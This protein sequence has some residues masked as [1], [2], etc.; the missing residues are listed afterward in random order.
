MKIKHK[1][2]GLRATLMAAKWKKQASR[3]GS[4]SS[5]RRRSS[6]SLNGMNQHIDVNSPSSGTAY[7]MIPRR[8][9]TASQNSLNSPPLSSSRRK[10]SVTFNFVET[11]PSP[12]P[13]KMNEAGGGGGGGVA[14][15]KNRRLSVSNNRNK[16]FNSNSS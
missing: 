12:P 15:F 2:S 9:S 3:S 6:I 7:S 4:V 8:D 5:E 16:D 11:S 13:S 10:S 14:S 1:Y